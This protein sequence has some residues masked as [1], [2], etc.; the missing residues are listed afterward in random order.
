M[1]TKTKTIK[2]TNIKSAKRWIVLMLLVFSFANCGQAAIAAD[3]TAQRMIELTNE[4][5]K[6]SGLLP[7]KVNDKLTAAAAAKVDDMFKFQYFDHNSP[8]GLTPWHWIRSAGYDYLYAGE[9]LAIDF[10]TA[11]GTHMALM[12]SIAHRDNILKPNYVEI[13]VAVKKG[14]F[15]GNESIIIVEQFGAPLEKIVEENI[16]SKIDIK[17]DTDVNSQEGELEKIEEIKEVKKELVEI[18]S[19]VVYFKEE[20]YKEDEIIED[21]IIENKIEDKVIEDEIK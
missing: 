18:K 21:K 7:L 16:E 3:I 1:K 12:R 4:S 13:G 17:G 2:E 8:S 15:E 20:N 14:I 19:P 11:E 5:R 6:D 10:V 9:N